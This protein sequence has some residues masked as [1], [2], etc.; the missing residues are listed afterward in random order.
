MGKI[1][2]PVVSKAHDPLGRF[3]L[4]PFIL[5]FK[6]KQNHIKLEPGNC[7]LKP[8]HCCEGFLWESATCKDALLWCLQQVF[9]LGPVLGWGT[10]ISDILGDWRAVVGAPGTKQP[11]HLGSISEYQQAPKENRN[12]QAAPKEVSIQRTDS[13]HL[14]W[15][16]NTNLEIIPEWYLA[17]LKPLFIGTQAWYVSAY[18][19][20]L[21]PSSVI[22]FSSWWWWIRGELLGEMKLKR[23]ESSNPA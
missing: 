8:G 23:T 20:H 21:S 12:P 16:T 18:F 3:Q 9:S 10:G 6:Q 14:Q 4:Q 5:G 19:P 2:A 7:L 22:G 1:T 11:C 17:D 13:K 15:G